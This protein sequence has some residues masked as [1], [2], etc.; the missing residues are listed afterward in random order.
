MDQEL[1][2]YKDH[3][4]VSKVTHG[5]TRVD[6]KIEYIQTGCSERQKRLKNQYLR[7]ILKS[8]VDICLL[9]SLY[10]GIHL[11]P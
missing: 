11:Q 4:R 10:V 7:F 9:L 5:S 3:V 6:G 2:I 1:N 8:I